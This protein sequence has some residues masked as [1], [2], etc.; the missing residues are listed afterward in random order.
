[1]KSEDWISVKEKLPEVIGLPMAYTTFRSNKVLFQTKQ[2]EMFVGIFER[3]I[4]SDGD[5]DETWYSFG[6]GGR[7]MAAKGKVVAWMPLPERYVE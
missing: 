2:G 6:T 3:Y 5:I 4:W 7:K 1:M